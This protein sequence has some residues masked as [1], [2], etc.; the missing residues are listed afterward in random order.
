MG[1][2]SSV[3]ATEA[4]KP[5]N[6]SDIKSGEDAR[7]EVKRLRKLLRDHE[8]VIKSIE[9]SDNKQNQIVSK[10][11]SSV[12]A[13]K[14]IDTKHEQKQKRVSLDDMKKEDGIAKGVQNFTSL[15]PTHKVPDLSKYDNSFAKCFDLN[16]S[17]SLYEY[18]LHQFYRF[19]GTDQVLE[20]DE[21]WRLIM[22]LDLGLTNKD[23]A[24]LRQKCDADR[25]GFITWQEMVETIS[26]ML[27]KFWQASLANADDLINGVIYIGKNIQKYQKQK[28]AIQNLVMDFG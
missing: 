12:P 14:Q 17:P 11:T 7:E 10:Q 25:D 19:C 23:I 20:W 9:K 13:P 22:D 3:V 15:S 2:A 18:L 4:K 27:G 8:D 26:P 28:K 1:S 5:L 16:E 24:E 6:C 21:F